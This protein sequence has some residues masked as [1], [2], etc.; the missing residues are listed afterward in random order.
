MTRWIDE[1]ITDIG[2]VYDIIKDI[3]VE[4]LT[5]EDV[6]K[7]KLIMFVAISIVNKTHEIIHAYRRR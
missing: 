6:E 5:D 4:Q 3:D 7:L 2:A 1:A